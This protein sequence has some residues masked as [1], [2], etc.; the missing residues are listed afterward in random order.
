MQVSAV[1]QSAAFP[2]DAVL[3]EGCL[4]SDSA[5]DE[6]FSL[7]WRLGPGFLTHRERCVVAGVIGH[8]AE[9]VI[10]LVLNRLEWQVLW[11]FTGPGGHGVDLVLLTPDG[12]VVAVEVKGT[13]VSGRVPRLSRREMTQMSSAWVDKSDNPA[14]A[15]LELHSEDI[16]GAVAAVNF[17]DMIWRIALTSDF[18]ALV[19][20]ASF[21]QLTQLGW[22]TGDDQPDQLA[23]GRA[24]SPSGSFERHTDLYPPGVDRG[25]V[26]RSDCQT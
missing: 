21:E 25:R 8:V 22:L 3:V 10:E 23:R 4:D 17:A 7:G 5:T 14:M 13:L 18:T 16:Y 12:N 20:V 6:L 9:S 11:H 2:I 26:P 24:K 15:E 1:R 19:P